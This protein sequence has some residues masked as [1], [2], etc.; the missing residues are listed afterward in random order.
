MGDRDYESRKRIVAKKVSIS[1]THEERGIETS[2]MDETQL[3]V[4]LTL[5]EEYRNA[6]VICLQKRGHASQLVLHPI[7]T[8]V[9][10]FR[11]RIRVSNQNPSP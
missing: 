1:V 10:L 4:A 6:I 8:I 2:R 11:D 3:H 7:S 9:Q 5:M